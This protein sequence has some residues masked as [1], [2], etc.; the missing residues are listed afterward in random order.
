MRTLL[1]LAA[2]LPLATPA[3]AQPLVSAAWLRSHLND[4][5]LVVLDL[6]PAAEH[7]AGHIPGAD[8]AD[9]ERPAGARSCRT[10]RAAHCRRWTGSPR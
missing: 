3:L 7:E 2:I 6:R 5:G 9:Y 4:K 10:G 8:A 1:A